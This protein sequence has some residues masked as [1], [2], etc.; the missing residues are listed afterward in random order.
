MIEVWSP[1]AGLMRPNVSGFGKM[2]TN[3]MKGD[4]IQ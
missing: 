3:V 1:I 2:R 4:A